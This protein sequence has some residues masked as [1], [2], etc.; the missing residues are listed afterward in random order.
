[1]YPRSKD[2]WIGE[3]ATSEKKVEAQAQYR[4]CE[5]TAGLFYDHELVR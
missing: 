1:M 3:A 4:F 2:S 5:E